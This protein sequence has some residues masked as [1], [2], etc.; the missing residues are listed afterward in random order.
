[1]RRPLPTTIDGVQTMA[2]IETVD[3]AN[4]PELVRIVEEVYATRKPFMLRHQGKTL[5]IL[6]PAP[7]T[8]TAPDTQGTMTDD[9]AFWSSFGGWQGNVDTDTLVENAM[10]SRGSRRPP[11]EL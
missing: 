3:I 5:A 4:V 8:S 1:M 7:K 2:A 11:V 6:V 9:E 10:A